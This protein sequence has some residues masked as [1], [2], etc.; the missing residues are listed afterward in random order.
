MARHLNI[1]GERKQHKEGG[2]ASSSSNVAQKFQDAVGD[3]SGSILA[4]FSVRHP[5]EAYPEMFLPAN[6][7]LTVK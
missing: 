6:S 7:P 4:P 5:K 3:T 1:D 2:I